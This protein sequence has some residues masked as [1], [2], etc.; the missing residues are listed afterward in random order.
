MPG[1]QNMKSRN[2]K[3]RIAK[4]AGESE[5]KGVTLD[6]PSVV[7]PTNESSTK[8]SPRM[9]ELLNG[10]AWVYALCAVTGLLLV[11]T[12]S[13]VVWT[14]LTPAISKITFATLSAQT[15]FLIGKLIL[16]RLSSRAW[17]KAQPY[18]GDN[19]PPKPGK[20]PPLFLQ[21]FRYFLSRRGP[22]RKDIELIIDDLHEDIK[23]MNANG[24]DAITIKL[25]VTWR[26]I[27]SILPI[28]WTGIKDTIVALS[29]LATILKKFQKGP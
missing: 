2:T 9:A 11:A 16:K 12:E 22:A 6:R 24:Y 18:M 29:P 27:R 3:K 1:T 25:M 4:S 21:V 26:S 17:Q 8:K 20:R 14:L 23:E 10:L 13:P 7:V 19:P 5:V 15:A 28:V